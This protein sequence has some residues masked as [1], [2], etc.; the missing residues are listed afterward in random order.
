MDEMMKEV[1]LTIRLPFGE[2]IEANAMAR[3]T[4]YTLDTM[5]RQA[6]QEFYE[7]NAEIYSAFTNH[8]Q[9]RAESF[10]TKKIGKSI[11]K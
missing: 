10:I 1:K 7:R 2:Q 11:K 8:L 4:G 9:E 5:V 3:A 6:L